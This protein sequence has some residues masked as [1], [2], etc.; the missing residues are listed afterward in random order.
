MAEPPTAVL[1]EVLEGETP[2]IESAIPTPV[3]LTPSRPPTPHRQPVL[4]DED[5]DQGSLQAFPRER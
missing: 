1:V 4:Q 5:I 2:I 3:A